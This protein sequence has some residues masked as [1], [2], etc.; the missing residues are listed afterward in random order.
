MTRTMT[1][2]FIAVDLSAPVREAL[3]AVMRRLSRELPSARWVDPAGMHLTLAFLG[4]LDDAQIADA[5]AATNAAARDASPLELRLAGLG[6]FGGRSP[7]VIWAGIG[8]DVP[9]LLVRQ[10]RLA[11][12]LAARGFPCEERPFSP[13]LT[14]AR[15]KGPLPPAELANLP[16]ALAAPAPSL[17]WTVDALLVMKSE[18][19]RSGAH[20]TP[21]QRVPL[22]EPAS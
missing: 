9:Q 18:R 14:L 13:H 5:T 2:T 4:D 1:R 8:G 7:R 20:Y 12:A 6:T 11:D 22:G 17:A 10:R 19:L 3:A 15:V 21:L 16:Q